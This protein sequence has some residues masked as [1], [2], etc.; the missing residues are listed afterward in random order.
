MRL[1]KA[2]SMFEDEALHLP[3][4]QDRVKHRADGQMWAKYWAVIV[5]WDQSRKKACQE[6]L[7]D[8]SGCI[9]LP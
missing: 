7:P 8:D 5:H 9:R 1:E 6:D 4:E 2:L 3:H